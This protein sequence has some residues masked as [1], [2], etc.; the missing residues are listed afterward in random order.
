MLTPLPVTSPLPSRKSSFGCEGIVEYLGF[1]RHGP[2]SHWEQQQTV[3]MLTVLHTQPRHSTVHADR[4]TCSTAKYLCLDMQIS[5]D[6]RHWQIQRA[7]GLPASITWTPSLVLC[8]ANRGVPHQYISC[9]LYCLLLVLD[10]LWPINS[11]V[12]VYIPA[13]QVAHMIKC[14][15]SQTPKWHI[16]LHNATRVW[17]VR[18]AGGRD[19]AWC[20]RRVASGR[21][22]GDL[23]LAALCSVKCKVHGHGVV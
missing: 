23:G 20:C 15:H 10:C 6:C 4:W 3:V 21:T 9:Q 16:A 19:L 1:P 14:N 5:A 12:E 18:S 7:D 2:S 11:E 13:S 22:A 8:K 17:E